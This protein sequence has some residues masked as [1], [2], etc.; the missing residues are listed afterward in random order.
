M[1]RS[2][3]DPNQLRGPDGKWIKVGQMVS[4]GGIKGQVTRTDARSGRIQIRDRDGNLHTDDASKVKEADP[5]KKPQV[6]KPTKPEMGKV[7]SSKIEKEDQPIDVGSDVEKA[8]K[9]LAEGKKVRL[10]QPRE[11]ATLLDKLKAMVDEAVEKGEDAPTYDL[12]NVSVPGTN[13]FCAESKGIPRT[14]MPQLSG[15]PMPGSKADKLEKNKKGEVDLGQLFVEHLAELGIKTVREEET[16]EK[17]RASQ[18][19]LN[20]GKVAGMVGFMQKSG[21]DLPGGEAGIFVSDEGYVIDG[22]HRWAAQVALDTTD[23]VLGDV[24]MPI[25]RIDANIVDLLALANQFALDMG[26]PQVAV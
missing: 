25:R 11:V 20:G 4:L 19:Q 2:S 22:H 23:G 21:Q 15:K 10:K 7:D 24:V 12:C 9:L 18:S 17:L 26:V 16:A 5:G 13:L 14:R 1:A 6:R 8:A 3:Y